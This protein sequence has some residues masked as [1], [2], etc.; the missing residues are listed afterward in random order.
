MRDSA[1][2][3]RWVHSPE[4][5]GSIPSPANM[6][7]DA[8]EYVRVSPGSEFT[9][10]GSQKYSLIEVFHGPTKSWRCIRAVADPADATQLRRYIE[11]C[12]ES[13]YNDGKA[14]R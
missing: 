12:L 13:A 11:D 10:R 2:V 4:V 6:V 7:F 3:A 14:G 1:A 5:E 8:S 9:G